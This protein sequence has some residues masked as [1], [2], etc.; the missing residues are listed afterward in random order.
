MSTMQATAPASSVAAASAVDA[1]AYRAPKKGISWKAVGRHLFLITMCLWVLLPLSWVLL[2]SFKTLQ[3]GAHIWIWPQNGFI[4]PVLKNY[5][6]V[7]N[8]PRKVG[9]IWT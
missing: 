1:T 5:D 8:N 4:S 2:L 7:L 9:P 3:D 6:F